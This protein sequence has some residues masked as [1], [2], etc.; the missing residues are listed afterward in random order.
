[1][2]YQTGPSIFTKRTLLDIMGFS[3]NPIGCCGIVVTFYMDVFDGCCI[4][5]GIN[6]GGF[7]ATILGISSWFG[8]MIPPGYLVY[9]T[10][11]L[12]S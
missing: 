9:R 4:S 6:F 10:R 3:G 2:V 11:N 12:W 5:S 7:F 8:T 1:M